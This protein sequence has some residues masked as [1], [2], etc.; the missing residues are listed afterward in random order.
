MYYGSIVRTFPWALI[1]I[2]VGNWM[3]KV[4]NISEAIGAKRTEFGQLVV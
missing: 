3:L 4:T 1:D 2:E